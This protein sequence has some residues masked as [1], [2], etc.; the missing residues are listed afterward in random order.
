MNKATYMS[1]RQATLAK[2]DSICLQVT[3]IQKKIK[4]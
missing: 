2:E 4:K 3:F 1:E